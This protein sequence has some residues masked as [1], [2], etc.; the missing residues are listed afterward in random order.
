MVGTI[1]SIGYGDRKRV[2]WQV[3]VFSLGSVLGGTVLGLLLYWLNGFILRDGIRHAPSIGMVGFVALIYASHEVGLFTVP[4]PQRRQQVPQSWALFLRPWAYSFAYG[5]TL[6]MTIL[7]RIHVATFYPV[8]LFA[9]LTGGHVAILIGLTIGIGRA[10]PYL[11]HSVFAIGRQSIAPE[12]IARKLDELG[13]A[14]H[15][16]NAVILG[17]TGAF[18]STLFCMAVL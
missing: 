17:S 16:A 11:L 12:D 13:L 4:M 10:I 5:S 1:I 15:R 18:L 8:L 9:V 2:A 6:G 7:V 3:A 14:M